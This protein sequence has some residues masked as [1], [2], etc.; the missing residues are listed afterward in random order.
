MAKRKYGP[1]PD[2]GVWLGVQPARRVGGKP[3]ARIRVGMRWLYLGSF[4][5]EVRAA[6][7][8]DDVVF[9][10]RGER[11]NWAA[12]GVHAELDPATGAGARRAT[13]RAGAPRSSRARD[14]GLEQRRHAR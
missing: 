2:A 13:P 3:S 12:S 14:A 11:P 4:D 7:G 1:A 6:R 10:L 5:T 8:V 9:A